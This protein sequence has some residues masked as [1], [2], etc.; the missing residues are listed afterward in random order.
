MEESQPQ[1]GT[2]LPRRDPYPQS[3]HISTVTNLANNASAKKYAHGF[4]SHLSR[5]TTDGEVFSSQNLFISNSAAYSFTSEIS[6]LT[7]RK[8]PLAAP[9]SVEVQLPALRPGVRIQAWSRYRWGRCRW[10]AKRAI[11]GAGIHSGSNIW[12]GRGNTL[13]LMPTN[14]PSHRAM[15]KHMSPTIP[16]IRCGRHRQCCKKPCPPTHCQ[17]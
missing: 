8:R 7:Q 16:D 5:Y 4:N 6:L 15:N 9:R 17:G 13:A 14:P 11:Y 2:L 10:W 12:R 3:L 1:P